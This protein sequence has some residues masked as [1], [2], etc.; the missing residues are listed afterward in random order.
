MLYL[1]YKFDYYCL[2]IFEDISPPKTHTNQTYELAMH[3]IAPGALHKFL[4]GL[5]SPPPAPSPQHRH[6]M[7]FSIIGTTAF[8]GYLKACRRTLSSP[9]M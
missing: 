9:V 2:N 5:T 4:A 8:Q 1:S 3:Y 6:Y 7:V